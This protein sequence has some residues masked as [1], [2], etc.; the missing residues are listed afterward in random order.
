[1]FY[2]HRRSFSLSPWRELLRLYG[3]A[4]SPTALAATD[5]VKRLEA[6]RKAT[7]ASEELSRQQNQQPTSDIQ[8]TATAGPSTKALEPP[9]STYQSVTSSTTPAKIPN[10]REP[11]PEDDWQAQEGDDSP[12]LPEPEE[13]LRQ[14]ISQAYAMRAQRQAESNKENIGISVSQ[15]ESTPGGGRK[16]RYIDPQANAQR[17]GFD[18]SQ[19]LNRIDQRSQMDD[20]S[21]DEGFQL[22]HG[23]AD[24]VQRRSLKPALKRSAPQ[25]QR[26]ER[27]LPKKARTQE[28]SRSGRPEI[29]RGQINVEPSPSPMDEYR[30]ANTSA[31][32][33]K[34]FQPK[35]PQTR[36]PWSEEETETLLTLIEEHGTSWALLL[37]EDKSERMVL[38]SRG[39]V[40]LKDKARNMKMDYLK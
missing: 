6:S 4:S 38:Q 14:T 33:I 27:S 21:E 39:Q 5:Y 16:S 11:Q 34:T 28:V 37:A 12:L 18:E 9:S 35:P 25:P 1:M 7:L 17:L 13:H 2:I 40:A 36:R 30:A 31:K 3:S 22:Q 26:A 20:P 15:P 23:S 8:V 29:V 24:I 10:R 32:D 19:E